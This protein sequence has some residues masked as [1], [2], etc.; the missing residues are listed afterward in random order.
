MDKGKSSK[1]I[2][3]TKKGRGRKGR[4][5]EGYK[6]MSIFSDSV[7]NHIESNQRVLPL[8]VHDIEEEESYLL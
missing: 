7:K 2:G 1:R 4:T 6:S 5:E 8:M 3:D